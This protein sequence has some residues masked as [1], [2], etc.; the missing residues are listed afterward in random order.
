MAVHTI[1]SAKAIDTNYGFASIVAQNN[2]T[3]LPVCIMCYQLLIQ[4]LQ[5]Q[6]KQDTNY[7]FTSIVGKINCIQD[8]CMQLP[9]CIMC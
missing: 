5:Q 9:V 6:Q 8:N 1:C 2:C 4:Y 7:G 3:Q